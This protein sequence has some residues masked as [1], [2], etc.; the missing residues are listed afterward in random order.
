MLYE[1]PPQPLGDR[2]LRGFRA[3]YLLGAY[4]PD[5]KLVRVRSVVLVKADDRL[6]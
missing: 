2:A 4:L 1:D 6:R 5:H 3:M